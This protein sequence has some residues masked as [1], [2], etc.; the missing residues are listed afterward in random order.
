[1]LHAWHIDP[2]EYRRHEERRGRRH[3]FQYLRPAQTALV[4]IDMVPFFVAASP[5]C[6]GIVPHIN[7]IAASL[8]AAAGTV[9]WVLPSDT[10]RHPALAEEFFGPEI[11]ELYR[12]SGGSGPHAARL[13]PGL[14]QAP[15]DI[16]VEKSAPSAFLPGYCD[17]S[18]HLRARGID[19]VLITG[20]VTNVCCESSARDAASTG[21]RVIMVADAN[22]AMR[23]ADHNATLHTIYRSFG[24][25]RPTAEVLALITGNG[26]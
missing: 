21:F 12:R 14:L 15:D 22:A 1:M 8:R 7:A 10:R 18:D 5:Y 20:T 13:W 24:D 3:A 25:V 19:T 4:V 2:R 9:A 26:P 16:L 11:A 17:L 23:D 6:Q